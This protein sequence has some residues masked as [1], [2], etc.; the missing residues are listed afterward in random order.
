V[1]SGHCPAFLFTLLRF[2]SYRT[3]RGSEKPFVITV[4]EWIAKN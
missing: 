4:A 1:S 3:N 2:D